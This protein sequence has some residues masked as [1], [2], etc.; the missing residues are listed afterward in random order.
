MDE[1]DRLTE[2]LLRA[3]RDSSIYKVYR[4][5]EED[6]KNDRELFERVNRFR[7]N[8]FYLQQNG[9]DL[10]RISEQ[11]ARE[12]KE[13]RRIS[14]VNAYLDAELDFCRLMQ[15]ICETLTDG[16]EFAAPDL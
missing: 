2:E 13:L 8:N 11:V 16:I 5:R 1:I 3:I 10:I 9:G 15:K 12:S 7:G 6:L 14:K 4:E